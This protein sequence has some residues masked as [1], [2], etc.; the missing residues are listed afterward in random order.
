MFGVTT[1][2]ASDQDWS[3]EELG[4]M[5]RDLVWEEVSSPLTLQHMYLCGCWRLLPML[6]SSGQG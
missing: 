4:E 6:Y 5:G 3:L 1:K 2:K